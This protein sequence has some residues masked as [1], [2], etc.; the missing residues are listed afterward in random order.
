LAFA[1]LEAV[2][3]EGVPVNW[4]RKGVGDTGFLLPRAEAG[5]VEADLAGLAEAEEGPVC[6][7]V[8][9]EAVV[10]EN[11]DGGALAGLEVEFMGVGAF[12]V[13]VVVD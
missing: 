11:E 4:G 1:K 12:L 8:S 7:G 3:F 2:G 10:L 13:E 5:V 9:L 6:D